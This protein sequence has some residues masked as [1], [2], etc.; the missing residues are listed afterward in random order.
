MIDFTH[1]SE[2]E[3]ILNGPFTESCRPGNRLDR[4][5]VI[6]FGIE[7]PEGRL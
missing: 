3:H 2:F 7:T 1:K 4:T 6:R 5:S